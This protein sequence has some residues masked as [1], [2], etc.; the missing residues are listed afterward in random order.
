MSSWQWHQRVC[1]KQ[2]F[3]QNVQRRTALSNSWRPDILFK[4]GG[5]YADTDAIF[6]RPLSTELRAYDV[7]L[8]YDW[9]DWHQP[10]PDA[11]NNGIIVSKQGARFWEIYLVLYIL[12][13]VCLILTFAM[14]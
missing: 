6:V 10:F 5:I 1:G 2:I 12:I 7:V 3:G 13:A 4:Y 8:S 11:I 9:P 14:I